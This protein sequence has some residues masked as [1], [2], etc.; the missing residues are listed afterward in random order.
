MEKQ[1]SV[2]VQQHFLSHYRQRVFSLMSSQASPCPRYTFYSDT[3]SPEGIV[4]IDKDIL[5]PE[6]LDGK[7]IRW[8]KVHNW[9]LGKIILFQPEVI[10]LGISSQHDCI[11]YLGSMYHVTTWLS[12]ILA[13]ITGKKVL[14]WT[15][16]YLKEE[17]GFKGYMREVFYRMAD[18]LLLYGQRGKKIM[19]NR[20][21]DSKKLYVV[22]NSLDYDYQKSIR[23]QYTADQLNALR[24]THFENHTFP[25]LVFTGR[26]TKRKGLEL[27]FQAQHELRLMGMLTNVLVIGDGPDKDRLEKLVESLGLSS[28]VNFIGACY[29]EDIIGPLLMM[30]DICVSPGE[31]GLTCIHSMAYGIPVITHD[32]PNSQGPEWEAIIQGVTGAV[33]QKGD[34]KSLANTISEWLSAGLSKNNVSKNCTYIVENYY[35][36]ENQLT[37][38]NRAVNGLVA[39]N[40][41]MDIV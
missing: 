24:Q 4:T 40:S 20:G 29:D 10:T 17:P 26:V 41:L 31:V 21:F 36:P 5:I 16:G 19:E 12:A 22:Y 35:S 37:I 9:W 38:I 1:I 18:G 28:N 32:D 14:M 27:I 25:V 6:L 13:K 8:K 2:A 11:I 34:F 39:E 33:F 23:L 7:G 3:R 15:H 30:S